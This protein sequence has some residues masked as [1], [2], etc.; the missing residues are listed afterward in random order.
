M[1]TTKEGKRP[2]KSLGACWRITPPS[3][4]EKLSWLRRKSHN[5]VDRKGSQHTSRERISAREKSEAWDCRKGCWGKGK[6]C[7]PH[8]RLKMP[9]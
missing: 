8:R 6:V 7:L 2:K 9:E 1:A 5:P 3:E 4:A